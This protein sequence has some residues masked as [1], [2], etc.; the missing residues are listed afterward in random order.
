MTVLLEGIVGSQAYG[1]ATPESDEDRLGVFVTE[2][3]KILGLDQTPETMVEHDPDRTVHEVSKFMRLA[4]QCNPHALELLYLEPA[5]YTVIAPLGA[6]LIFLRQSFLSSRVTTSY[7][8]YAWDQAQRLMKR[9]DSFSSDTRHRYAKHARHC[10]RLLHQGEALL[11]TGTLTIKVEDPDF[12][13]EVGRLPPE[14]LYVLFGN[15]Y[16]RFK[17]SAGKSVLP[18]QPDK[19]KVNDLLLRIRKSFL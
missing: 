15:A 1:L 4:L 2:T 10:F 5:G 14:K 16:E 19:D 9:G 7:G 3:E 12:Y 18:E 6:E 11:L 17:A 13:H 8:E